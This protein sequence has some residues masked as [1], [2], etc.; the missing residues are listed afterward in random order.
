MSLKRKLQR[1]NETTVDRVAREVNRELYERGKRDGMTYAT[2]FIINMVLYTLD[3]KLRDYM[4]DSDLEKLITSI[5]INIDSF[6]TDHLTSE[7]YQVI[8]RQVANLVA[9]KGDML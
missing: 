7:D 6:R 2:E 5:F 4:S 3:Y 1:K 9:L 8:K